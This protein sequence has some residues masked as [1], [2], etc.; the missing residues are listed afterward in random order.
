MREAVRRPHYVSLRRLA[1][2]RAIE[3]TEDV[4]RIGALA[5]HADIGAIESGAGALGALA[6]AARRSAF[7]AVRNVATLG[8]NLA[9]PFPE[10]DLVPPLLAADA[11]LEVAVAGELLAV[12]VQS[13]VKGER[14]A[15]ALIIAARVPAPPRRRAWFE[16][17]TVRG[18]A[19][20]SIVSVAVSADVGADGAVFAARVAVGAVDDVPVRTAA[21]EAALTGS[22]LDRA[23]GEAAGRAASQALTGRD[24][25]DAP[26]LV[27]ARG[28]SGAHRARRH[29]A[30][31]GRM[32][33]ELTVN[34]EAVNV[35]GD[36]LRPLVQ[37]LRDDCGLT[38]TKTGCY[39][40]TLRRVH[41]HRRRPLG[42]LV[43][44]PA[45]PGKRRARAHGRRAGRRGRRAEPPAG[46]DPRRGRCAVR[47]LDAGRADDADGVAR[48][49]SP[50][51]RDRRFA[52]RSPATS[53]AARAIRRSSTRC[54]RCERR[55]RP[56]RPARP[57]ARRRSPALRPTAST[58][59][60]RGCCTRSCCAP[61]S[62]RDGSCASTPSWRGRCPASA[63]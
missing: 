1:E 34:G 55:D 39:R 12:D 41:G 36:G 48:A 53:A 44:V 47:H 46:R 19:E 2:L 15:G 5:T 49:Q 28:S 7:P 16:R 22:R 51:D 57:T 23:A 13:W 38:G 30:G 42:R 9:A 50:P 14:P 10:A 27:P 43:P 17:L 11:T 4:V 61:P 6:E 54:W 62:R 60:F 45:R 37:V 26:G 32:T 8:G 31:R 18:G 52:R 21:A 33:Y 59:N 35:D 56:L 3:A 40:G 29:P 20:Y 58:A 24:G 25:L 63:R